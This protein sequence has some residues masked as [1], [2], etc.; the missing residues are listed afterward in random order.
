MPKYNKNGSIELEYDHP[1]Y[2]SIPFTSSFDDVEELGRELY[3]RALAGEFGEIDP[4]VPPSAYEQAI[5][6]NTEQTRL[7]ANAYRNESDPIFLKSQRGDATHDEWLA[8]IQA[9]K[10]RYP[11]VEVLE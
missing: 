2:G 6:H 10:E 7:R 9:I 8:S 4:Y 5:A 3:Q 11:M 1:V